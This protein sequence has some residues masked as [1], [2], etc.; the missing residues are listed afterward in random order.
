M[1]LIERLDQIIEEETA[2][3]SAPPAGKACPMDANGKHR[4][5]KPW[6]QWAK[7]LSQKCACGAMPPQ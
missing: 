3:M 2:A 5:Q 6:A 7:S 1:T 4:W